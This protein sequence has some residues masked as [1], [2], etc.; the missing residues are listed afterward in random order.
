M[1]CEF[2]PVFGCCVGP[3]YKPYTLV[4]PP[5]LRLVLGCHIPRQPSRYINS[6]VILTE[7]STKEGCK[8]EFHRWDQEEKINNVELNDLM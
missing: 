3:Q 4:A 2:R 5:A 8:N 6:C 1:C 7:I